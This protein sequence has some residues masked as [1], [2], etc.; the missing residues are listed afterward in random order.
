MA[1][2]GRQLKQSV[3]VFHSLILYR[4][5]PEI[6]RNNRDGTALP[7][8]S[9]T[10]HHPYRLTFV[11]ESIYS[12]DAGAFVV[13]AQKEKILWILDLVRQQEANCLQR[14]LPSIDVISKKQVVAFW[15]KTSIFKQ[16]QKIIIL[17]VNIAY[18]N[19]PKTE[20]RIGESCW[21]NILD[22]VLRQLLKPFPPQ[23]STHSF[24]CWIDQQALFPWHIACATHQIW[25]QGRK[26]GSRRQKYCKQI[27]EEI[28]ID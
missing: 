10:S 3:N 8:E 4:L 2:T 13:S 1:A 22:G 17:P 11:V 6:Y 18:K 28:I 24:T 16:S 21:K 19:E 23:H 12:V 15:R 5:L 26:L 7:R 27:Y 25:I 20:L 9:I 14:L